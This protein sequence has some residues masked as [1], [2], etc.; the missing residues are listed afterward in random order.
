MKTF[1][2]NISKAYT[3]SDWRGLPA[4][5]HHAL[6]TLDDGMRESEAVAELCRLQ[7]VY[8]WPE[9]HLTLTTLETI[10]QAEKLYSSAHM[11][12]L[13]AHRWDNQASSTHEG[14]SHDD[15]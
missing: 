1:S 3:Q 5:K 6:V 15:V 7:T 9:F 12:F 2:I 8:P 10:R 11:D 13:E 14:A 4:H